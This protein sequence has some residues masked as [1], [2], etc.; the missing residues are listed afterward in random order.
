VL[1]VC[2]TVVTVETVVVG[3][4]GSTAARRRT[5]ARNLLIGSP[6]SSYAESSAQRVKYLNSSRNRYDRRD[7]RSRQ[8]HTTVM[9]ILVVVTAAAADTAEAVMHRSNRQKIVNRT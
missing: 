8:E 4:E 2:T 1:V 9:V 7:R 5:V 6:N 3:L